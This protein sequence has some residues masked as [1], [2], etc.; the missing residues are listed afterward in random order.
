MKPVLLFEH[1]Q[2]VPFVLLEKIPNRFGVYQ[3]SMEG[4][5]FA[6]YFENVEDITDEGVRCD[7]KRKP[8]SIGEMHKSV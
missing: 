4:G 7:L 3:S 1:G 8:Q 2:L 5:G 6:P